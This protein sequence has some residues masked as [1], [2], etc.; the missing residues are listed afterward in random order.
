MI[1]PYCCG[2]CSL[3]D[4]KSKII[5]L[6]VGHVPIHGSVTLEHH[7]QVFR[8]KV[9]LD[10]G[11]EMPADGSEVWVTTVLLQ[12][13]LVTILRVVLFDISEREGRRLTW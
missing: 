13:P 12:T 11:G 9:V 2:Q 4:A 7:C 5:Y 10:Y 8:R 1:N 3:L 6:C